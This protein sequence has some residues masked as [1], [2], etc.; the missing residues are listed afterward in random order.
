VNTAAAR[1]RCI[2]GN[3]SARRESAAGISV[4]SPTPTN[5][6]ASARCPKPCAAPEAAVIKLQRQTPAA[7]SRIREWRSATVPRNNPVTLK[8][9]TKAKSQEQPDLSA[10]EAQ[11]VHQQ[12]SQAG[13]QMPV[14]EVGGR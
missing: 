11:L 6:R 13:E 1:A 12:G 8:R 3:V 7:T 14:E 2:G 4:A 5:T 10:G 9:A